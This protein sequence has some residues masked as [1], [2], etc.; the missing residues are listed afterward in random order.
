M[1]FQRIR[2]KLQLLAV[3]RTSSTVNNVHSDIGPEY[4]HHTSHI[5]DPPHDIQVASPE[6]EHDSSQV[7]DRNLSSLET[8]QRRGSRKSSSDQVEILNFQKSALLQTAIMFTPRPQN[9]D[10][11]YGSNTPVCNHGHPGVQLLDDSQQ[12][13]RALRDRPE[14]GNF[15]RAISIL[16]SFVNDVFK[17]ILQRQPSLQLVIRSPAIT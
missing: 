2:S 9:T 14:T 6:Q 4:Q 8:T 17:R 3:S 11:D 13:A 15:N 10:R 1:P 7:I 16:Y 5:I 12:H